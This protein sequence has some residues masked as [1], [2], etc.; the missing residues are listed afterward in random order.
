MKEEYGLELPITGFIVGSDQSKE[1]EGHSHVLYLTSW[2]GRPVHVHEFGGM[3]SFD[4]GHLHQYAGT[5]EPAPSG[6][7][8]TH[9]YFTVTSFDSGHNHRINGET[10]PAIPLPGGGHYH[11]F[12]G[13]TSA[14]GSP[15]HEH[16]YSGRTSP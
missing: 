14:D 4:M 3:T 5:T 16:A 7:P 2:G 8:H 6:V 13:V 9:S 12:R 10:G 15:P 11:E 1:D